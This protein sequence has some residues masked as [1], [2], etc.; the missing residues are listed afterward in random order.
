MAERGH[1]AEQTIG[2]LREAEVILA[3]GLPLAKVVRELG[4]T[5]Q[6]YHS[7][8]SRNL[9]PGLAIRSQVWP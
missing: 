9:R 3:Q 5:E 8:G 7:I 1:T 2:K 4:I 6:P